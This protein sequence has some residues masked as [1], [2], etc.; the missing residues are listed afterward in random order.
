MH[1]IV[2]GIQLKITVIKRGIKIWFKR[3]KKATMDHDPT[4]VVFC[5]FSMFF[6]MSSPAKNNP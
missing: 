5:S 3:I 6:V 4:R 2:M 1:E